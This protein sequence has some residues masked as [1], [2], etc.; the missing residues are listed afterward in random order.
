MNKNN[1]FKKKKEKIKILYGLDW[2]TAPPES[3]PSAS[4]FS[5]HGHN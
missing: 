5:S 3:L 2:A 1:S 4:A